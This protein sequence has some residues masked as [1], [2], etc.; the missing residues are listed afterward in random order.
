MFADINNT[1]GDKRPVVAGKVFRKAAGKMMS[2]DFKL[3]WKDAGGKFQY[4]LKR[5]DR[6]NMVV[7]II[8]HMLRQNV[9]HSS[10]TVNGRN[11]FSSATRQDFGNTQPCHR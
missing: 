6:V 8:Q 9:E 5:P 1:Q 10:T 2:I 4:G 11:A 3:P 7:L